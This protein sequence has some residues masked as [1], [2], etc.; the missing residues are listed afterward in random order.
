M[1]TIIQASLE[2]LD[3]AAI[4]FDAYRQFY[5]QV[6]DL[7]AA[8]AF[9]KERIRNKESVIFLA[10]EG[11]QAVGLTQLYPIFTS[12]GLQ[13]AWLL[14]DLYV[15]GTAR[16][17]GIAVQLLEAAKAHAKTTNSKWL[18]LETAMDNFTAQSVYEK[19]GWKRVSDIFYQFDL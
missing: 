1:I 10:Y 3:Q 4:L 19:N 13:R 5:Q 9:L 2:D 17:K 16:K 14:N 12:V 11:Q 18:L 8:K 6:P 15:D 7:S